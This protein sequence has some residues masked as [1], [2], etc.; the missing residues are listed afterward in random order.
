MFLVIS[1]LASLILSR[2][3]YDAR[4][5]YLMESNFNSISFRRIVTLSEEELGIGGGED[6]DQ[7]DEGVPT[8]APLD[9]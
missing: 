2:L 7:G 6:L 5:I 4:R 9:L 8:E 1:L 3:N